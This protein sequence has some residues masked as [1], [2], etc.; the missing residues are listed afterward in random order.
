MKI[1]KAIEIKE[2]RGQEFLNTPPDE[3]DQAERLSIEALKFFIQH[4]RPHTA[5]SLPILPSETT[6]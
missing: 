4:R 5:I 1:E 3:I 6:K 2:R